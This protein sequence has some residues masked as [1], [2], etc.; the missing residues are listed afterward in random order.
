VIVFFA[1]TFG[2]RARLRK[3]IKDEKQY[4]T[5]LREVV[6]PAIEEEIVLCEG[7]LQ[8]AQNK[9]F[10][11]MVEG[12]HE[13]PTLAKSLA[14]APEEY[15]EEKGVQFPENVRLNAVEADES[16][17]RLTVNLDVGSS[18]V[19]I[20]WDRELGFFARPISPHPTLPY[21]V[22]IPDP[23]AIRSRSPG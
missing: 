12:I 23:A 5:E 17:E 4:I 18:I 20:I 19:E 7:L 8:V 15:F 1:A 16:G 9:E 6:I 14:K 21:V 3:A 11:A 2:Q 13:D 10:I 22:N